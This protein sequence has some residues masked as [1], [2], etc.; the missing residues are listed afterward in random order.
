MNR[1]NANM[2]K[3]NNGKL[4]SMDLNLWP[5]SN[6]KDRSTNLKYAD[7]TL[8]PSTQLFKSYFTGTILNSDKVY[9]K[10]EEDPIKFSTHTNTSS[11]NNN[12]LTIDFSSQVPGT[13]GL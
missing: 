13:L 8:K 7:L 4:Y 6:C 9:Y 11:P 10:N 1:E 5:Y 3:D 2:F 12:Y